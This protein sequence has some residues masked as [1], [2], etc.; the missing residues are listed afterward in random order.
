MVADADTQGK[1]RAMDALVAVWYARLQPFVADRV[2]DAHAH[3][4]RALT[5][6]LKATPDGRRS[7]A[8]LDRSRSL[9]SAL[10]RLDAIT[11]RMAGKGEK[12]LKGKV[13]EARA[14]LYTLA[15]SWHFKL[16]PEAIRSRETPDATAAQLAAARAAAVHGY[17]P[18]TVLSAAVTTQKVQL[19][20]ALE[21]AGRADATGKQSKDTLEEW[22]VRAS[23]ALSQ[24]LR[25]LLVDSAGWCDT[26]AGLD[27]IHDDYLD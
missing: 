18:H 20:A 5:N 23:S 25:S 8:K 21:R 17:D 7:L 9:S 1:D 10:A 22:R 12:S 26:Q 3:A 14:Q 2:D 4:G 6:S 19:R 13:R 16:V 15:A 27:T 24:T 11:E